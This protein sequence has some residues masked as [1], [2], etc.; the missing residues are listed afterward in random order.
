MSF[1][2]AQLQE[3]G[4]T[5][6]GELRCEPA[7]PSKTPVAVAG[8]VLCRQRPST[9]S[10]VTFITLEDETGIA[11]LIVWRDVFERHRRVGRL[12]TVL[13][14]RGR[15]ERQGS[16]VHVHAELL[17]SLDRALPALASSSRD[18]H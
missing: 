4:V 2:R 14:V 15:I 13:L 5:P 12:S 9:A 17:E 1:L 11:N 16:V 18:F 7:F 8:L 3:L 6:A 10:G